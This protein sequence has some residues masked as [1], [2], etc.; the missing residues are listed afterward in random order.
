VGFD[1]GGNQTAIDTL[2][3]CAT[4]PGKFYNTANGEQLKEAFR[5]IALKISQLYL[6]Q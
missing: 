2:N 6:T 1:L 3:N 5:D 4:E